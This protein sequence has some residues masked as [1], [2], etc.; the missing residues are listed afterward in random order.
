MGSV[1]EG[2]EADTGRRVA[3]KFITAD[4]STTAEG[5]ERFRRE[6][7]LAS[8]VIHPRCV[9][10]L[11]ADEEAGQPYI[12]MELMPGASLE[13][14][15]RDQGPLPPEQAVAKVLDVIDGLREA[16]ALGII[17]RD[18]KPSNCFL[19][20]DGRV[21]IGDFGLSRALVEEARLTQTGMFLGTPLFASPEQIKQ[22]TIDVRTDVYSVAATLYFLLAGH[23]PFAEG[24]A[25]AIMA[26]VISEPVPSLRTRRPEIPPALDR[27]VLRGLERERTR[28]W[29]NLDE[30]R[31][32]LARF[33]PDQ[34][35]LGSLGLRLGAYLIDSALFFLL[36]LVADVDFLS[37]LTA[38]AET[39]GQWAFALSTSFA[40]ASAIYF[41]VLEGTWGCS[42]GKWLVRL[43]VCT[44]QGS[45]APGIP[46]AL[47]RSVICF[48]FVDLASTVLTL[49]TIDTS[50]ADTF[51]ARSL[52]AVLLPLAGGLL[53]LSTMRAANG[54]RGLHELLSGTR[55]VRLAWPERRRPLKLRRNSEPDLPRPLPDALPARVGSLDIRSPISWRG[56]EGTVLGEDTGL[57]RKVWIEFRPAEGPPLDAHRRELSRPTRLRWLEGGT[58]S[59]WR[60]D[61][62]L[63]PAGAPLADL[64]EETAP[65]TWGETR[66]ILQQ[67]ADELTSACADG[68]LPGPL[69]IDQ[70]CV[71]ADGRVQVTDRRPEKVPSEERGPIEDTA[72]GRALILLREVTVLALEGRPRQVKRPNETRIGT[73]LVPISWSLLCGLG[74]WALCKLFK[75]E[76][77]WALF[78]GS[79]LLLLGGYGFYLLLRR[80]QEATRRR[81]VAAALPEHAA[82]LL[83]RLLGAR[84][85]YPTLQQFQ[86]DLLAMRDRPSEVNVPIR[87]AHL[88][89]LSTFLL[90][91][92]L[93]MFVFS[94]TIAWGAVW[95]LSE[96]IENEQR[97]LKL[98]DE[99]ALDEFIRQRMKPEEV[100]EVW[101]SAELDRD[102]L[103]KR[104]SDPAARARLQQQIEDQRRELAERLLSSRWLD[105]IFWNTEYRRAKQ[106][107][108][109]EQPV[110]LEGFDL[111]DFLE[112][113]DQPDIVGL[114]LPPVM[115]FLAW[116]VLI[117]GPLL[118]VLGAFI[119]RGGLSYRLMKI[120]LVTRTGSRALR[121]QCAWRALLVWAPVVFLLGWSLWL[122]NRHPEL[123][124][125]SWGSWCTALA[126]LVLYA[127]LALLSPT[128]PLH[129]RLAGTYLV[130]R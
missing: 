120:S 127:L 55:V 65:L 1:W 83:D 74:A 128:R 4:H 125:L 27:V 85:P 41:A 67:L 61:A 23:A 91:G 99:Q 25:T 5:V 48:A 96:T 101:F 68:T 117:L 6:G 93:C 105:R 47:L 70:V 89:L 29:Q 100:R 51:D 58:D 10:V 2:E 12:V 92:L 113:V 42:L 62:F 72:E 33:L 40:L 126:L 76:L 3:V 103:I 116:T 82:Q 98:L 90:P 86:A 104:Y 37:Q 77:G 102:A 30:F 36:A 14:L 73:A 123:A 11:S 122:D 63:A 26:R 95:Q 22:E 109:G 52:L 59:Q 108:A 114:V 57:G 118:W 64:V 15:V 49:L 43:R 88:A 50:G 28:R 71:Q 112:A 87:A 53:L 111:D 121:L 45:V 35:S 79:L 38:D 56:T 124:W 81:S 78:A 24:N 107:A 20:K 110:D 16:H 106:V 115:L 75:G 129:D 60:W 8:Q 21:K 69:T 130:P 46:R 84:Q 97:A 54:Y 94:K 34:L 119:F 13:D 39:A 19:E 31:A 80:R 44:R 7:R 18:I 9:F 66:S 32:A 17:H